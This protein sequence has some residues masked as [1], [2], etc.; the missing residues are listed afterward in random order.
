[1]SDDGVVTH[2]SGLGDVKDMISSLV[3]G[4]LRR[5]DPILSP[6][7]QSSASPCTN[8]M[9]GNTK[10]EGASPYLA[11]FVDWFD[12]L[13]KDLSDS[14]P[15]VDNESGYVA[16]CQAVIDADHVRMAAVAKRDEIAQH[17]PVDPDALHQANEE[18][19]VAEKILKATIQEAGIYAQQVLQRPD[20]QAF[21]SDRYDDSQL[22]TYLILAEATPAKLAQWCEDDPEQARQLLTF[23]QDDDWMRLFVQAG[24]ARNGEYPRAVQLYHQINP[25]PTNSVLHRLALAV[26]LEL[27]SPY[28]RFDTPNMS[29]DPLQRYIHYEQAYLLGELDPNFARFTVWEMRH[30]INSD[31]TEEELGWGRQSLMNYRPDLVY[32]EDPQWQYCRIVRTDISYNDPDW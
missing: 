14:L 27:S 31:A 24:G 28:A 6:R 23:L 20:V 5:A 18:V 32:S 8:E 11:M 7:E 25:D 22:I 30:V 21:L 15:I 26:A 2:G 9:D 13:S 10:P 4:F 12:R 1:M 3:S 29:V 16:S 19:V 17:D